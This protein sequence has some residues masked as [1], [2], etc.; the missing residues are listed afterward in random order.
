MSN[1]CSEINITYLFGCMRSNIL[2][3]EFKAHHDLILSPH[4][5]CISFIILI[6]TQKFYQIWSLLSSYMLCSSLT[7]L[8]PFLGGPPYWVLIFLFLQYLFMLL[9]QLS[10]LRRFH[11]TSQDPMI[12]HFSKLLQN[13]FFDVKFF[14]SK[15]L[16]VASWVWFSSLPLSSDQ[17]LFCLPQRLTLLITEAM[18]PISLGPDFKRWMPRTGWASPVP[19][20]QGP[21]DGTLVFP[22]FGASSLW[23]S[24][25]PGLF[26]FVFKVSNCEFSIEQS[27]S[28][29]LFEHLM[30]P[31]TPTSAPLGLC[32]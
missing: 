19:P 14:C 26:S 18:S 3:I 17:S 24:W 32:F 11:W 31:S 6:G 10:H 12:F 22:N 16:T 1:F 21:P 7:H 8:Y 25:K 5:N 9:L 15:Q 4:S 20:F 23:V 2:K 29:S 30:K 13:V 27:G 28:S